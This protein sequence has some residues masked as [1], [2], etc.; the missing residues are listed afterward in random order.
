MVTLRMG[1]GNGTEGGHSGLFR[2]PGKIVFP[3]AGGHT[4]I[5]T[6]TSILYT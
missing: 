3:K 2:V 1:G 5:F 4:Q 6:I